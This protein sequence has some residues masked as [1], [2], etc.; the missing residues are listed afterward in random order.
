MNKAPILASVLLF[1]FLTASCEPVSGSHGDSSSRS[2]VS[3]VGSS[4]TVHED[5]I[6]ALIEIEANVGTDRDGG[7]YFDLGPGFVLKGGYLDGNDIVIEQG[8]TLTNAAAYSSWD[9]LTV[10]FSSAGENAFLMAKSSYFPIDNGSIGAERLASG[11]TVEFI[12][13]NRYFSIYAAVGDFVV[14]GIE[15]TSIHVPDNPVQELEA[16]DIYSI[17]DT[18]GAVDYIYGDGTYQLGLAKLSS[19]YKDLYAE[20]PDGTAII[21]VGD[22]WQGS[23]I[24]NLSYGRIMVEWMNLVGF[25]S[26]SIGNHEFDWGTSIIAENAE[27]ANF[28]FLGINVRDEEGALPSFLAPSTVI[29]RGGVRIG[30]IGGIGLLEGSILPSSLGGYHFEDYY[31][32]VSSE[33]DR[34][35]I[36][37]GCE[38]VVVAVHNGDFNTR[39]CHNIDAVLLGH[40]HQ[41]DYSVDTYGIP[42]IQCYANGSNV[43]SVRFVKDRA[44]NWYYERQERVTEF[45][46][47]SSLGDDGATL[48]L[49]DHYESAF[50]DV[51]NEVVGESSSGYDRYD[52]PLLAAEQMYRYYNDD[53]SR[54][55][56]E[57]ACTIVN[58]GCARQNIQPGPI[59]YGDLYAV[60]PFDND[61]VFATIKGA[62]L[63]YIMSSEV[64]YPRYLSLVDD[65]VYTVAVI[66]YVYEDDFYG[67]FF[68]EEVA[69][70]SVHRLR[71]IM[72]DYLR[73]L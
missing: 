57:V 4:E 5:E 17:N 34:L 63:S 26:M 33:A 11:E 43:R 29:A 59:T 30:I 68:I 37:E 9:G 23:A 12:D 73:S 50:D 44:G 61:H 15:I 45:G 19:L 27:I 51:M 70:D 69:R 20:N 58:S 10:E 40:T 2:F 65:E 36:E 48:E 46:D 55:Y 64:S 54:A 8:G 6:P 71:D 16:I 66:S 31:D 62:D 42:H 52:L 22:M 38:L 60:F 39:L 21:S 7:V 47:A 24:S 72:A 53:P 14:S 13:G 25:D 18:H 3:Y 35:R 1:A 49:I 32:L 67:D 41:N 28:P 56:P